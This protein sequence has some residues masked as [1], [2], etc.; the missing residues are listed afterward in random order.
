MKKQVLITVSCFLMILFGVRNVAQAQKT[1]PVDEFRFK[2]NVGTTYL[3]SDPATF[4]QPL[5]PP[6]GAPNILLVLLDDAGFGQFSVCGGGVPSPAMDKLAGQG[7]IYTRFHTT[8]LCSPTRAALITGRNANSAGTGIITELATGY[9]GYTGI[10]PKSTATIAEILRQHGYATAWIGKNHNTPVY[11][12]SPLGPFDRWPNGLGFDYFYGFM[13]GDINQ[14]KPDLYENRNPVERPD[15]PKYHLTT[16]LCDHTIK[17]IQQAEVLQPDKPWFAYLAT[18]ATHSPHQA[19]P[20]WIAKFKGKFDMGWDEYRQQTFE[21]QKKLGVIPADS[22]L[23]PRPNGLPAWSTLSADQKKLYSRM[24]EVFA[25]YGAQVDYETGRV[26]DY[27]KTLPDADNTMIIYIMGDN[28]A[29][30]EGAANGTMNE[31]AMFNG[32]VPGMAD[33]LPLID[34]LGSEKHFNHFPAAWAWAMNTPFQWTKQVASHLGGVRNPMIISWPAKIKDKHAIRNQFT[35]CTDIVPTILEATGIEEPTMVNG[36]AQKPME[37]HSFYA[38]LTDGNAK[39]TTTSQY[40]EMFANRGMYKDGWWASSL[41]FAPWEPNRSGF[42]PYK[43]KWELYNLNTDFTQ[44]TDL[45]ASNPDKL[46]EMKALWWASA[47][48]YNNLPLDW[49]AVERFSAELSGKPNPSAGRYHFVYP[50]AFSGIP[51]ATAPDLKNRSFSITAKVTIETN[52]SGMIFTQ[53]GNTGGWGFYMKDGQVYFT[54]NYIDFN[55]YTIKSTTKVSAGSHILKAEFTYLGG[56]EMGKNGEVILYADGKE[57]ARGKID[58][59]N[60][61]KYSLD[62]TQDIGKDGGTPV[63]NN[64]NPPFAFKGKIEEV[65]IDIMK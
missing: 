26:I 4:P 54:H 22:K 58:K 56:K 52:N 57:I 8:A 30:A 2:G 48:K 53:G 27:V 11:E 51:E 12:T 25:A 23:T 34:E 50:G 5:K 36:V 64:Y 38:S 9:D 28:G 42:D 24:M 43:A 33:L 17:W 21:R 45:A 47:S 16:D 14:F 20:E 41:S 32:V 40:F 15:D 46:E 37:G 59:T 49:R 62:E 65:I 19:P 35:H 6:A 13:A 31:V 1:L 44:A 61:F 39:E 3:N 18:A 7:L 29:S 63:D 55:R 10:I 60:P